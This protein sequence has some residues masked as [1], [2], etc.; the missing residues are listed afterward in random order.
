[1]IWQNAGNV[2]SVEKKCFPLIEMKAGIAKVKIIDDDFK[3]G[4]G[5]TKPDWMEN[6]LFRM[7]TLINTSELSSVTINMRAFLDNIREPIDRD[8][9]KK[10]L[11][12]LYKKDKEDLRD[13]VIYDLPIREIFENLFWIVNSDDRMLTLSFSKIDDPGV[14]TDQ[15]LSSILQSVSSS[16]KTLLKIVNAD[17]SRQREASFVTH[18]VRYYWL[19][20]SL[21]P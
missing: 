4:Y 2:K 8:V 12:S 11:L 18:D 13:D 15:F 14:I 6:N 20:L 17:N 10:S 21:F 19:D 16:E 5:T 3:I 1:M 9:L 7:V